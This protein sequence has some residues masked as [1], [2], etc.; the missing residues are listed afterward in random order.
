LQFVKIIRIFLDLLINFYLI[1]FVWIGLTGGVTFKIGSAKIS[2]T[3]L[4]SILQFLLPLFLLRWIFSKWW[5]VSPF[6]LNPKMATLFIRLS[7]IGIAIRVILIPVVWIYGEYNSF[8]F[9]IHPVS[10]SIGAIF[11]LICF[12]LIITRNYNGLLVISS[13]IA[14]MLL[15]LF[16]TEIVLRISDSQ[17]FEMVREEIDLKKQ[18]YIQKGAGGNIQKDVKA[19]LLRNDIVNWTW[20]HRVINNSYGFRE[21]EFEIP[22]S[23]NVYRI[24]VLGDSITWGAGLAPEQRY[25]N[26][27]EKMLNEISTDKTIEVLNF[28]HAGAPTVTERDT[29]KRLQHIVDPDLIIVGFC[30]NDP[31]PRSQNY[32]IERARVNDLYHAIA[33]LRHIGLKNTYSFLIN[34]LDSLGSRLGAMPTWQE[35]LNRTYNKK[36]DEWKEFKRALSDISAIA[37]KRHIPSPVMVLLIT[38]IAKDK[39][40]DPFYTKWFHQVRDMAIQNGFVVVNPEKSFINE[41][42][43]RDIPVNPKDGHPSEKCHQIYAK[44]LFSTIIPIIDN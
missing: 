30:L 26:I 32:S 4:S 41:I 44:D 27:L 24:M 1:L 19:D 23:E 34:R 3:H 22:K 8:I 7:E 20:G 10:V 38:G 29:L 35:A 15:L 18:D 40:F 9:S 42:L 36:S 13:S 25:T 14:M 21:R 28:A 37:D 12:R 33:S 6:T 5:N 17:K 43:L 16:S 31:Q 2:A 11:I 39:K